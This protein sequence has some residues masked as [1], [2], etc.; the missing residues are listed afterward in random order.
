MRPQPRQMYRIKHAD[1][2]G[3][4]RCGKVNRTKAVLFDPT[5]GRSVQVPFA[6]ILKEDGRPLIDRPRFKPGQLVQMASPWPDKYPS[7]LYVVVKDQ[8][9]KIHLA[10]FGGGFQFWMSE[11]FH[12]ALTVVEPIELAQVYQEHLA[13]A[14]E[15][16]HAS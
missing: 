12:T 9:P 2:P 16:V 3:L 4:Y 14:K 6:L 11:D 10:T 5:S 13:R 1:W 8:A 7:G 15:E